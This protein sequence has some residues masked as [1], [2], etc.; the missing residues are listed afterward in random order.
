[1]K[2]YR[3]LPRFG[4]FL[5]IWLSLAGIITT[6][7][8]GGTL[9]RT[10]DIDLSGNIVEP[11]GI[12]GTH[13]HPVSAIRFSP[14]GK[15]IAVAID[16][17][18]AMQSARDSHP[19]GVT[20]VLIVDAT[21]PDA[22]PRQ[23]TVEQASNPES[24]LS[25]EWSPSGTRLLAGT[26][27]IQIADGAQCELPDGTNRLFVGDDEILSANKQGREPGVL[28]PP[29]FFGYAIYDAGCKFRTALSDWKNWAIADFAPSRGMLMLQQD[30]DTLLIDWRTHKIIRRWSHPA[31]GE[32]SWRFANNGQLECSE[33]RAEGLQ[34]WD[35]ETGN[36]TAKSRTAHCADTLA[37]AIAQPIFVCSHR[38]ALEGASTEP[39]QD[40]SSSFLTNN[41][42]VETSN[43]R[44]VATW[45]RVK[46]TFTVPG[47]SV[48]Q[49]LDFVLDLSA[50][51]QFLAEG[52]AGKLTLYK[53]I[54]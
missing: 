53:V 6:S 51:G 1:M 37:S 54:R 45:R 33:G 7:A 43:G 11:Q 29:L 34:C 18:S 41:L 3:Y 28:A 38:Q 50:D 12:V 25:L 35:I 52:G 13:D 31:G 23:F 20:H 21:A 24:P 30:G 49:T 5:L 22:A 32:T 44:Q 16:M 15:K 42:V 4:T 48:A 19:W 17:H 14:D 2:N 47:E 36:Q 26:A 39:L 46:Q 8:F 27:L 10:W 9:H 40:S